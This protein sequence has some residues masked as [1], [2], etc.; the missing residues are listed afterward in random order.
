MTEEQKNCEYCHFD[1]RGENFSDSDGC[2]FEIARIPHRGYYINAWEGE[3]GEDFDVES[4]YI[5]YCP[6]CGRKLGKED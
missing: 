4:G 3:G 1:S 5:H 2:R 6:M